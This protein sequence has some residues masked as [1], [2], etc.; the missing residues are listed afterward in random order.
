MSEYLIKSRVDLGKGEWLISAVMCD[1]VP[2][3]FFKKLKRPYKTGTVVNYEDTTDDCN[4]VIRFHNEDGA[5]QIEKF[6]KYIIESLN[7][8][9]EGKEGE[10]ENET[11]N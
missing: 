5:H 1:D 2:A 3:L 7:N 10:E 6:L 9:K 4:V 11:D 8:G